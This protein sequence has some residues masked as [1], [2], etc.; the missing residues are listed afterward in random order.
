MKRW[1]DDLPR[2]N[3]VPSA[4]H[5]RA[6]Q[7]ARAIAR[8]SGLVVP[9][10]DGRKQLL[11]DISTIYRHD[12]RTGIQRI[13]HGELNRL[14]RQPPEGF[15]VRPIAATRT[16]S[17]RYVPWPKG[18]ALPSGPAD[19]KV[20]A[21]DVFFGLDLAAHII[22]AHLQRLAQ[23]KRQGVGFRFVIYD[24][25]PLQNPAWF[26]GKLVAAFRRWIKAV[27]MLADEAQ[28]ISGTV[29]DDFRH[30]L[31]GGYGLT[32]DDIHASV[33]A[34]PKS[35]ESQR[36]AGLPTDF[37]ALLH[38]IRARK[39]LL[40]VG[41]LEPRKGHAEVMSAFERLWQQGADINLVIVG[42]P[43]W[44]TERLQKTLRQHPERNHRLFWRDDLSDEALDQVYQASSGVILASYAEGLGLPL[45]EAIEHGRPVLYRDLPVFKSI[46][47]ACDCEAATFP[48]AATVD[49][50]AACIGNFLQ[51]EMASL[52]GCVAGTVITPGLGASTMP[53]DGPQTPCARASNGQ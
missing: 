22:P 27:A 23:W 46:I 9:Q 30:L 28:C 6:V 11:V 52:R 31:K 4:W 13:V 40:M 10:T 7:R 32:E 41:T 48:A 5:R 34:V 2:P 35:V 17:Y 1:L 42:R 20:R 25:L 16:E 43:G 29:Q 53:L 39:S 47:D 24:L 12:A 45:I 37:K 15:V 49:E 44:K 3:L 8:Q 21:G 33:M 51:P 38:A 14:L 18:A 50:L 36:S 19:V 26:S